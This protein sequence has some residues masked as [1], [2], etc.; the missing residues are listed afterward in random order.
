MM[1]KKSFIEQEFR[2]FVN[3]STIGNSELVKPIVGKLKDPMTRKKMI[4]DI[5]QRQS[6]I[7]GIDYEWAQD[8]LCE[9]FPKLK[10]LKKRDPHAP[11]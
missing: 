4:L 2:P 3:G 5:M 8:I 6:E 7:E 9:L 1:Y 11:E 10:L